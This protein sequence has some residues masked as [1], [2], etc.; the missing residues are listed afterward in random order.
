MC[1]KSWSWIAASP[2]I[3]SSSCSTPP[4]KS[5]RLIL[6]NNKKGH[7][8]YGC[9]PEPG[10]ERRMESDELFW[11][12]WQLFL[13]SAVQEATAFSNTA[14]ATL[15]LK[16]KAD[17]KLGP[18]LPLRFKGCPEEVLAPT[19]LGSSSPLLSCPMEPVNKQKNNCTKTSAV[20]LLQALREKKPFMLLI[21]CSSLAILPIELIN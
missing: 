14:R 20:V 21:F 4:R 5:L 7:V 19:Q 8:H 1:G 10:K 17:G 16:E 18:S 15:I 9:F 2:G 13:T 12:Q 3:K 11:W 6:N